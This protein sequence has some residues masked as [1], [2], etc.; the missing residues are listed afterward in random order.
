MEVTHTSSQEL[1][2]ELQ[3]NYKTVNLSNQL[4]T[5]QESN[6]QGFSQEATLRLVGRVKRQGL[7][8]HPHV[9]VENLEG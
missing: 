7:D 5:K 2:L 4:R 1:Q 3:L 9:A 6:N 8:L